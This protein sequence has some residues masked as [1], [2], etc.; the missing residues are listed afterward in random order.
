MC[1]LPYNST[2]PEFIGISA[3]PQHPPEPSPHTAPLGLSLSTAP[4]PPPP[5]GTKGPW[6][7][8]RHGGAAPAERIP[9]PLSAAP[10]PTQRRAPRSRSSWRQREPSPGPS[11][12]P[13]PAAL[14]GPV[15]SLSPAAPAHCG[16][17]P[18]A[19]NGRARRGG[20]D[21]GPRVPWMS[22][23]G[24]R[25][26]R[27]T[28]VTAHARWAQPGREGKKGGAGRALRAGR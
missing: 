28:P 22:R 9:H 21:A 17:V 5:A 6:G 24:R 18:P 14:P 15:P 12:G 20:G 10:G 2:R 8:C 1:S 16:P 19:S 11:P 7:G 3:V 25:A 26:P 13:G 27:L 4:G 23:G